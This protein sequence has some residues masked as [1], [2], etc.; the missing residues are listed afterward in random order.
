M[1]EMDTECESVITEAELPG[2]KDAGDEG[3]DDG[4][5]EEAMEEMGDG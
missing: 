2:D 5:N 3:E 4:D 1:E